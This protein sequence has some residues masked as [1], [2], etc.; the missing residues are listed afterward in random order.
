VV[1]EVAVLQYGPDSRDR[2]TMHMIPGEP[3]ADLTPV[4]ARLGPADLETLDTLV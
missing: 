2:F 1:R 3:S 4:M